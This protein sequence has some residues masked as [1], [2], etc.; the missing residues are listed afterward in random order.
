M[1]RVGAWTG[2]GECV[3]PLVVAS[4]TGGVLVTS[5]NPVDTQRGGGGH[6][7]GVPA[8]PASGWG[9]CAKGPLCGRLCAARH[10]VCAARRTAE[11]PARRSVH[12]PARATHVN[13][14]LSLSMLS[15]RFP[16]SP[17]SSASA[18]RS[19]VKMSTT[20]FW[21]RAASHLRAGGESQPV[22][23]IPANAFC[24]GWEGS[25]VASAP[26]EVRN[27]LRS[28]QQVRC[29]EGTKQGHSQG[30]H[31]CPWLPCCPVIPRVS[32]HHQDVGTRTAHTHTGPSDGMVAERQGSRVT[33]GDG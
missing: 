10:M 7:Q 21:I 9:S 3:S 17:S 25:F 19:S 11:S 31:P 23:A 30:V 16:L 29:K 1:T 26:N 5:F 22:R 20:S 24:R 33:H 8:R 13:D 15:F 2:A 12:A 4:H 14:W 27:A 32:R 6:S 18:A 28:S